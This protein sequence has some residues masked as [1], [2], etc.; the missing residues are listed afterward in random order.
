MPFAG[1]HDGDAMAIDSGPIPGRAH[2]ARAAREG[3]L[4]AGG[5]GAYK[6]GVGG[7]DIVVI[8][9]SPGGMCVATVQDENDALVPSMMRLSAIRPEGGVAALARSSR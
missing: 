6:S 3:R 8:G 4:T 5:N 9:A 7:D 1:V 2:S